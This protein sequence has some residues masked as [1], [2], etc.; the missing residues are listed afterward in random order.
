MTKVVDIVCHSAKAGKHTIGTPA[1]THCEFPSM[2]YADHE[3]SPAG[4]ARCV[5][6]SSGVPTDDTTR[7]CSRTV[8][9][10]TTSHGPQRC[11]V[12]R[13]ILEVNLSTPLREDTE[14]RSYKIFV[15]Q[16]LCGYLS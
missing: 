3:I 1:I 12:Y 14:N 16:I 5:D 8:C 4:N 13:E 15:T 6:R 7:R 2:L 9:M 11:A 10:L